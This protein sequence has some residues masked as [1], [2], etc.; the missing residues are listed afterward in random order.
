MFCDVSM[1]GAIAVHVATR[2]KLAAL[3]ALVVI[4]VV[5]GLMLFCWR[6]EIISRPATVLRFCY[7]KQLFTSM[8]LIEMLGI[9]VKCLSQ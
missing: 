7:A 2:Q 9:C 3:A 4:D 5:E 1:G 8:K 6:L